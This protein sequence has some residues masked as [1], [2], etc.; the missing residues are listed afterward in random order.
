MIPN[1]TPLL[2]RDA[3]QAQLERLD[4]LSQTL[5]PVEYYERNTVL[6]ILLQS[7]YA[8]EASEPASKEVR[9]KLV[10]TI[11]LIDK[12]FN[13]TKAPPVVSPRTITNGPG[14]EP[15]TPPTHL[16]LL[17][18]LD[19]K[20]DELLG[21]QD[22]NHQISDRVRDG[23]VELQDVVKHSITVVNTQAPKGVVHG[24]RGSSQNLNTPESPKT[25]D[26]LDDSTLNP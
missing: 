17:K 16:E 1:S 8:L 19:K 21:D 15:E 13:E 3:A 11:K 22:P 6:P 25:T 2:D 14:E 24:L 4:S 7:Y 9:D 18:Q 20:L 10:V 5:N 23:L 26:G 12:D